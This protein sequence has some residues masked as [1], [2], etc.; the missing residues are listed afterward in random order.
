MNELN[1]NKGSRAD[2]APKAD[3]AA[4]VLR[5]AAILLSLCLATSVLLYQCFC[6]FRIFYY[7]VVLHI[8]IYRDLR[9]GKIS[10]PAQTSFDT[11]V[12]LPLTLYLLVANLMK[13]GLSLFHAAGTLY[14]ILFVL[15]CTL[16]ISSRL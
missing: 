3:I 9:Y 8:P 11:L 1:K 14:V 4:M 10:C 15:L 2:F 16:V 5:C 12:I 13:T 7:E 6:V